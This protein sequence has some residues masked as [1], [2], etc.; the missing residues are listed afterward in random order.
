MTTTSETSYVRVSALS[1]IAWTV[2][3]SWL[4]GWLEGHYQ[5]PECDMM[6][7]DEA[8]AAWEAKLE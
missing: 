5:K 6:A 8:A 4:V 3:V 7:A 1:R 2:V